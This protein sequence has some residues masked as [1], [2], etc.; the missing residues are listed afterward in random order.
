VRR[1]PDAD[2][3]VGD[4]GTL[5]ARIGRTHGDGDVE[6]TGG[7]ESDRHAPARK[8]EDHG[9]G[10]LEVGEAALRLDAG[11]TRVPEEFDLTCQVMCSSS[12]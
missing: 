7:F 9:I 12:K 4:G 2:H 5:P 8:R 6:P 10:T 3:L 1:R 11:V